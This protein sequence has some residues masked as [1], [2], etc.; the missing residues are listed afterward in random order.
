[1]R[2]KKVLLFAITV[3]FLMS[4]SHFVFAGGGEKGEKAEAVE[5]KGPDLEGEGLAPIG[6]EKV[7]FRGWQYK[8]HIVNDKHD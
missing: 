5:V 1:M 2:F 8:T 7:Y 4:F 3:V 6:D